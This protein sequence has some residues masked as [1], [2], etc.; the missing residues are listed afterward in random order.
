MRRQLS[1]LILLLL[2]LGSARGQVLTK[3]SPVIWPNGGQWPREVLAMV[4]VDA[5]RVWVL[6]DGLRFAARI[7]GESD[8]VAVW[9]ERYVNA[10]GGVLELQPEG[11]PTTFILGR[12]APVTVR[13]AATA[14][15]R[16]VYPG[17]DLELRVEE[18][19]LKTWWHGADLEPITVAF[20]GAE[21]RRSRRDPS[22]LQLATPAGL[23]ELRAPLAYTATNRPVT[24]TWQPRGAHWTLLAPGAVRVDPTY[25]FSSFSGSLSDN[26]GYTATYDLKGRTWLGGVAFGAQFP[27]QNGIQP[28]FG[29]GGVDMVFMLFNPTGTGIISATYLGGS[30]Q[31]QPHSLR[32]APNGD[33]VIKGITTSQN[34]PVTVTGYDTSMA[35][36]TGAGSQNGG[37]VVYSSATDLALVRLDSTGS[38][39]KASTYYGRL[40]FDGIQDQ[41]LPHYGD[42]ARGDVWVSAQGVWIATAS[43]SR[44]M[45]TWPLDTSRGGGVDGLLAHFSPNLDSLRWATYVGGPDLDGLTSLIPTTT[46]QGLRLAVTGWTQGMGTLTGQGIFTAPLPQSQAYYGLFDLATGQRIAETYLQPQFCT[47]YG[48]LAAQNPAGSYAAVGDSGAVLLSLGLGT[49]CT[50]GGVYSGPLAP[51]AGLFQNPNSTQLLVWVSALGDSIYRTQYVGNGQ[52]N[53][54]ISPTALQVDDCGSAYFSGWFGGL[55]GGPITGLYTSPDALQPTTDGKDFY[56][57]VLD[58]KGAAAYASYFGGTGPVDEH[59]DGGTSRFDPNGVIHQ[60]ICAGCGGS[61]NLPIFPPNAH[62]A[63][64]NASN[65]N[66]AGIQIAFE[67][68]AAAAKLD[69]SVDTICA[70]DSLYLT[71]TTTRTDLLSIAWGDGSSDSLAPLPL[72]GHVYSVPGTYLIQIVAYDTLCLTQAVANLNVYVLPGS[73]VQADA[74]LQYDPCDPDRTLNLVPGPNLSAQWLVLY[75]GNGSVDT[76]APPY[77]WTGTALTTTYTAWLVAY[78]EVCGR[79]DSS[80]LEAAF[81]PAL[82]TP[83]ASVN[84]PPCLNGQSVRGLGIPGNAAVSYWRT[85][86]GGVI[87]GFNVLWPAAGAGTQTAWFVVADTICGTKDSVALTYSI[88]GADLDSLTMPNVFTPNGDGINDL[89]RLRSAE[90]QTLD[91]L[92]LKVYNRWGQTVFQTND[93]NFAWD[94]RYLDRLLSPG[95][96]VFHLSWQ[97][98]CGTHGDQHG[99]LTINQ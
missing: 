90:A 50:G 19:Y 28:N 70:G 35:V 55:N 45:A 7:P 16:G 17:V 18:G 52:L 22:V 26:F 29:G 96:Y 98:A 33:L 85:P 10:K 40:G 11:V 69:L 66:M 2:G 41:S 59:V 14:W 83:G 3:P 77:S 31:E 81:R 8:S 82:S 27:T 95:V 97:S 30:G 78:D 20:E 25:V 4:N 57:L 36:N 37:G 15:L 21:P 88:L 87:P 46:P 84:A 6:A 89:L 54:R 34:F 72:P 23:A 62:S 32:V 5:A 43:R 49:S 63:T 74:V 24:P 65:C 47:S 39:L 64:N 91:Q 76:L 58:R 44:G 1:F 71:G 51:T 61:D 60:A 86:A 73:A 80:Y 13:G 75:G 48:F 53:R 12:Q 93:P 92:D 9:T 38:A 68:T 94:G 56:F 67:L 42:P 79:R 99:T